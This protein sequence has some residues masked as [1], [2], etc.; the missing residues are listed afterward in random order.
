MVDDSWC[1]GSV[2][3]SIADYALATGDAAN[4]L[5]NFDRL[6]TYDTLQRVTE[7]HEGELDANLSSIATPSRM[8][9][10]DRNSAGRLSRDRVDLNA[11]R[12]PRGRGS[13]AFGE[14][15]D[16]RVY[17]KRSELRERSVLD[18]TNPTTPR[19]V[20]LDYDRNGNLTSDGE[21]HTYT[22]NPFGQLVRINDF[23]TGDLIARFTC[24]GP[25][26]RISEQTD[27][28][29]AANTGEPDGKV[30]SK[31]WVVWVAAAAAMWSRGHSAGRGCL[32][33]LGRQPP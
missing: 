21:K 11:N 2:Q 31:D 28:N 12:P 4:T 26:Q 29:T 10:L 7:L 14:M 6:A 16:T 20:A 27:V 8:Q 32:V 9:A 1:R 23:A 24:N 15:D 13:T 19:I 18:S 5:R 33:V 17:N 25:G 3:S 22:F 30:N